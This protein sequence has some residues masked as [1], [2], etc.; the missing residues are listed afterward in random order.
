MII[1]YLIIKCARKCSQHNFEVTVN[2]IIFEYIKML[3]LAL[4]QVQL[5]PLIQV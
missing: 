3:P 4:H 2:V 1:S 5:F